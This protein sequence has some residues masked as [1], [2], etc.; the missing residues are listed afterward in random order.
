MTSAPTC[1]F[2]LGL[3][4]VKSPAVTQVLLDAVKHRAVHPEMM[5]AGFDG[6]MAAAALGRLRTAETVGPCGT[7]LFHG[8]PGAGGVRPA[9]QSEQP[10]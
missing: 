1:A 6:V 4:G 10:R 3:M 5:L 7:F 8:T 2:A 9:G